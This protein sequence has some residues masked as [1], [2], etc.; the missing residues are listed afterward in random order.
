MTHTVL[1]LWAH[2]AFLSLAASAFASSGGNSPTWS[3]LQQGCPPL[4]KDRLPR[5]WLDWQAPRKGANIDAAQHRLTGPLLS[6]MYKVRL[7]A[8]K[9]L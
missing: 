7:E 2:L 5:V 3:N 6:V 9:C 8:A 4:S 1:L